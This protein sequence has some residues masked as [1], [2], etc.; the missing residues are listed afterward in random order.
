MD[1]WMDGWVVRWIDGEKNCITVALRLVPSVT[2]SQSGVD[3]I[4]L[5]AGCLNGSGWTGGEI[6]G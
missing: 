1:G 4:D 3:S 6:D 2:D 5:S